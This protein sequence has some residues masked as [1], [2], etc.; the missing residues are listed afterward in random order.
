VYASLAANSS[1]T[2]ATSALNP[3]PTDLQ[4]SSSGRSRERAWDVSDGEERLTGSPLLYSF[5]VVAGTT[6]AADSSRRSLQ[7]AST[8][9]VVLGSVTAG[10]LGGMGLVFV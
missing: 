8:L 7:S 6:N 1:P 2:A 5:Q 9:L 10:I 3:N 4:V